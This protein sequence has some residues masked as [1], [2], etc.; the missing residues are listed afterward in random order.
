MFKNK[1]TK[2]TLKY[3]FTF[4][5]LYTKMLGIGITNLKIQGSHNNKLIIPRGV[6]VHLIPH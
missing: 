2:K 4:S 5:L 1:Q 3:P 6:Y